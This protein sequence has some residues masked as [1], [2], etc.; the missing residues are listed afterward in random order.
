VARISHNSLYHRRLE[1]AR[2]QIIVDALA[3]HDGS[4]VAAAKYL[5]IDFGGLYRACKRLGIA[6][7]K[8]RP[9]RSGPRQPVLV[10]KPVLTGWLAEV[11][12]KGGS[13]D[14]GSQTT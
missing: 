12:S 8:L 10:R 14:D 3:K 13:D 1:E 5:G 11:A 6:V 7:E 2:R 9:E 4:V